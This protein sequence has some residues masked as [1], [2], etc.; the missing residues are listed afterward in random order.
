MCLT[1]LL[2]LNF[3]QFFVSLINSLLTSQSIASDELLKNES[4]NL[5]TMRGYIF[6][7]ICFTEQKVPQYKGHVFLSSAIQEV[8]SK[9][10]TCAQAQP[11]KIKETQVHI[12]A[13]ITMER[14]MLDIVDM[15]RY[16]DLNER[17][18]WILTIIDVYLKVAWTF[19]N[20]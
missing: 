13:K 14:L 3:L 20:V 6:S 15:Q 16:K 11:I 12:A 19:I 1:E 10:T 17:Y 5:I 9:Y 8:V 4:L 2:A 18:A 7:K